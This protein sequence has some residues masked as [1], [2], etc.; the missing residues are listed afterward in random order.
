MDEL[1]SPRWMDG[2]RAMR[3]AWHFDANLVADY[4]RRFAT[5]RQGV[6]HIQDKMVEVVQD[7]RG[8]VT[9][10]R[11][12]GG[13]TI[14]G[15]LFVDC[16]G[17]RGLL[18]NQAM[19]EPFLDMSDHLIND[20]A[21]AT[22]LPHD[23]AAHGVEPYTSAIAMSSGWTWKIPML[24][25]FGTGYVYSSRFCSEDDAIEEFSS[26]WGLDPKNTDFN[27]I[28]FRVGRNQRA[29][30]KNVVSVGLSSCFVEPLESTG[31][32]FITG[33]LFQLVK[34]FPDRNFDPV[35][36]KQFN[37]EIEAMFDDT[38]DFIQ[39]HFYYSPR[40]DTPFWRANKE[41]V[42]AEQIEEKVRMYE[43]GLVVNMPV[44]DETSYY[45]NLEAEFRNFWT[46]NNYYC[47]LAG[48]GRLPQQPL[49]VLA[50]RPESVSGSA[51]LFAELKK[52]Q[53]DLAEHLPTTYEYLKSFH[54]K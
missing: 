4:L 19:G 31:I 24:G 15:D 23:D 13:R 43:A 1:K 9:A 51:P 39:A 44:V 45:Q 5:S 47:V 37:Q 42:L 52:R 11:T 6:T 41:L 30:V 34:N 22:A 26:M 36:M 14:E 7:E 28:R 20:S 50:H 35:L 53:Q 27:R 3:Y 38:R 25:R 40:T 16:S 46:N 54:G 18:I 32:Y 8:F 49:P 12:E 21:V 17:F 2:T 33:A 48:L 10:L 29:W